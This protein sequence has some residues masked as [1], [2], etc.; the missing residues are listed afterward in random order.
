[1]NLAQNQ[2][3]QPP[4]RPASEPLDLAEKGGPKDGQ[5]QKL[6][7]RLFVQLTV[8]TGCG[9]PELLASELQATGLDCVLYAEANDP[10]GVGVLALSEDPEG[11]VKKLRPALNKGAFAPLTLKPEFSMLGRTYSLGYEP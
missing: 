9:H 11:F 5:P 4:A 2:P 3:S 8:F 7:R 6:D 10:R 1:M